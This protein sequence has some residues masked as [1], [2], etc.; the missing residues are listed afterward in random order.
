[1]SIYTLRGSLVPARRTESEDAEG[2]VS[3]DRASSG[4]AVE[5]SRLTAAANPAEGPVEAGPAPRPPSGASGSGAGPVE[6]GPATPTPSSG[7]S[8]SSAAGAGLG[9]L[10]SAFEAANTGAAILGS[11]PVGFLNLNGDYSN[12]VFSA[13][14]HFGFTERLALKKDDPL[15]KN[16]DRAAAKNTTWS[17]VSAVTRGTLSAMG[18]GASHALK[19]T[20]VVP[21]EHSVTG[22]AKAA[23]S[24]AKLLALAAK[25]EMIANEPPGTEVKM[26]SRKSLKLAY[27]LG[28]KANAFTAHLG[29]EGGA[30]LAWDKAIFSKDVLVNT[31]KSLKV[32]L[33]RAS[34]MTASVGVGWSSSVGFSDGESR[35]SI[36]NF[37]DGPNSA[38]ISTA[39][40]GLDLTHKKSV[41]IA[42]NFDP[43]NKEG[44]AAFKKAFTADPEKLS[45][46][47]KNARAQMDK[48][49]MTAAYASTVN[50]LDVELTLSVGPKSM[51]E[52]NAG[53]KLTKAVVVEKKA[54]GE[55]DVT[56]VDE[57]EYTKSTA[58]KLASWAFGE[59]R[60]SV[61]RMN[62]ISVNDAAAKRE[63]LISLNVK[64]P[65]VTAQEN[66][67]A[68]NF[69]NAMGV[70][71][72]Q[73]PTGINGEGE[74]DVAI[75]LND[76]EI[77]K[78]DKM[79]PSQLKESLGRSV[80]TITGKPLPWND[81]SIGKRSTAS[82]AEKFKD[83]I[84]IKARWSEAMTDWQ[85]HR[86]DPTYG[87]SD[88]QIRVQ[89]ESSTGRKLYADM[90][91]H[92][93][94][95]LLGEAFE[96]SR[97]KADLKKRAAFL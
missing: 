58:G 88:V 47:P 6:S 43:S 36:G 1:M 71:T 78:L 46:N 96:K 60:E 44:L 93:K 26:S 33:D 24:Q 76:A 13:G 3:A 94:I 25:P 18:V 81:D 15:L 7:S 38:N 19:I 75:S 95:E 84:S 90:N 31:D 85:S 67:E 48:L 92:E 40:I 73:K 51:L 4:G 63:L 23:L 37:A 50:S 11:R 14:Y 45:T 28:F 5:A 65:K 89:Y 9:W 86:A 52:I 12:S 41:A 8:G 35:P 39:R 79:T 97:G 66:L 91:V 82:R 87:P 20:A 72:D 53:T 70:K 29:V 10:G 62:D 22:V 64:D 77:A 49:G 34:R 42:G 21:V 69:A 32:R 74:L 54:N 2:P 16:K 61:V 30:D 17:E 55:V 57:R 27:A 68:S 83:P 56:R 59:E 80:E